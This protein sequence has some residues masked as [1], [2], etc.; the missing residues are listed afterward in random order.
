L[1]RLNEN[2]NAWHETTYLREV[3]C[4]NYL[5]MYNKHRLKIKRLDILHHRMNSLQN[6][7]A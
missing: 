3:A 5:R 4:G 1:T 6:R 7:C 2:F